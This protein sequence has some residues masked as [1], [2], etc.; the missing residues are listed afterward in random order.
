VILFGSIEASNLIHVR[1][2]LC[3]ASYEAARQVVGTEGTS[4]AAATRAREI[5]QSR[6]LGDVTVTFSPADLSGV[7]AGDLITVTVSVP[8]SSQS[9]L[10]RRIYGQ[11][12]LSASSSFVKE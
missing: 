6:G 10:P 8:T 3:V 9:M 5:M 11:S 12:T 1:E 7:V 2:S 4:A